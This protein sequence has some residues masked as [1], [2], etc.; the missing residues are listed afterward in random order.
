MSEI[1]R[2]T[3]NVT[4]RSNTLGKIFDRCVRDTLPAEQ[5]P[6]AVGLRDREHTA[7]ETK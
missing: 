5:L 7:Y 6:R 1:A 4:R 2:Q 3:P